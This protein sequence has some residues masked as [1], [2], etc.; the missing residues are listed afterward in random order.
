MATELAR[1]LVLR[2][3]VEN[4]LQDCNDFV[5]DATAILDSLEILM[6]VLM[7]GKVSDLDIILHRVAE[8]LDTLEKVWISAQYEFTVGYW[9]RKGANW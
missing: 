9:K 2:D 1:Y 5:R 8:E 6:F 3:I 4:L 7:Q